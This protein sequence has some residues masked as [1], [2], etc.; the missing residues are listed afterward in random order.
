MTNHAI[1]RPPVRPPVWFRWALTTDHVA[2]PS[3]EDAEQTVPHKRLRVGAAL[4]MEQMRRFPQSRRHMEKIQDLHHAAHGQ[5]PLAILPKRK[6]A[7][8]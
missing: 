4:G 3:L 1:T 6:L 7:I 8:H 5:I 2:H